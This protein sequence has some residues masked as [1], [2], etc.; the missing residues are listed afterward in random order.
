MNNSVYVI[1]WEFFVLNGK[2]REFELHYNPAGTWGLFFKKGDG[3]L[4][5]ELYCDTERTGRYITIDRWI[6]EQAYNAFY[7]EYRDEYK[8]N[9]AR[10]DALTEQEKHIGSFISEPYQFNS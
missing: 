8:T 10:C 6:S 3:Y 1:I 5:T 9:D 2:E 7:R 4:G